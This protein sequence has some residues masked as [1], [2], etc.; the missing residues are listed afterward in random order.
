M[1]PR[2][3]LLLS[4]M[5]ALATL[6]A[7]CSAAAPSAQTIDIAS[8]I[9]FE[10]DESF[11]YSLTNDIGDVIG[12]GVF[13]TTRVDGGRLLLRQFYL[14]A[15]TPEGLVP[16]SDVVIVEVDA[17]TLRPLSGSRDI[18]TR[19]SD[20]TIE[21]ETYRWTYEEDDEG[22]VRVSSTLT[23]GDREPERG[24]FEVRDHYYDNESSLW[25]WRTLAFVEEYD[26]FYVSVNPIEVTQQTV[27]LRVPMRQ[28]IEVPAGSFDTWRILL[29]NGRSVRTAWINADAPY[30]VVQWDNGVVIFRL[31]QSLD[32]LLN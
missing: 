1:V 9:A 30:Q 23:R 17:A 14:E 16:T 31:E 32:S 22:V 11:V 24:S 21:E 12:S 26:E 2:G 6:L 28:T 25:L 3:R 27:N 19:G 10:D 8:N 13:E 20:G 5:L 4:S 15:D 18:V 29:R 7:A